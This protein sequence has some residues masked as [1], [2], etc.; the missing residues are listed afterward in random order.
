MRKIVIM[1]EKDQKDVAK[2]TIGINGEYFEEKGGGQY[3]YGITTRM[4]ACLRKFDLTRV[5]YGEIGKPEYPRERHSVR[6]V[7]ILIASIHKY[8][9]QN[10]IVF[11]QI[12]LVN[13]SHC[14]I[15][16]F[17]WY[18]SNTDYIVVLSTHTST[19]KVRV[20]TITIATNQ[21]ITV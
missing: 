19:T 15:A 4:Y 16:L 7:N 9:P 18:R 2:R 13:H 5:I 6:L 8:M 17:S 10:R 21:T 1:F 12:L 3:D 20:T 14:S 11:E